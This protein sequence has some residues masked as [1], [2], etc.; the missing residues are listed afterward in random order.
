MT[1]P[2]A[3]QR[4]SLISAACKLVHCSGVAPLASETQTSGYPVRVDTNAKR[5][6][7]GAQ[8]GAAFNPVAEI[9]LIGCP[10]DTGTP[11]RKVKS[12]LQIEVV[13]MRRM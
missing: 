11:W 7:V 13:L 12:S 8:T 4:T 2:S 9:T 6:P 10:V 5:R 3:S 1:R